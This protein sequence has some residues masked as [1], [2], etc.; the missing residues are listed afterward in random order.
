MVIS[1]RISPAS[2]R[3]AERRSEIVRATRQ[4]GSAL[5][6]DGMRPVTRANCTHDSTGGAN[7]GWTSRPDPVLWLVPP[8]FQLADSCTG[9]PMDDRLIS[10]YRV[11]HA[12]G[13]GGMGE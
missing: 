4:V 6:A 12:L 13:E 7:A 11:L 8:Y 10:H 2:A 3:R 1:F 9:S 5:P